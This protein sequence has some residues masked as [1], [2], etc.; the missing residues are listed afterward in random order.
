M[1][2]YNAAR[3]IVRGTRNVSGTDN[4]REE[5]LKE[6]RKI[7]DLIRSILVRIAG[8]EAKSAP[9]ASEFVF[10]SV[11]G[12]SFTINHNYG[13]NVRYYLVHWE[14]PINQQ[15]ALRYQSTSTPNQLV[16]LA[17]ASG[18]GILRIEPSQYGI[19]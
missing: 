7:V 17:S 14:S 16:L 8:L 3:Q 13:C 10:T 19:R 15:T 9:E 11:A 2:F 18:T 1:K 5:D 6:P 4:L 12:Q